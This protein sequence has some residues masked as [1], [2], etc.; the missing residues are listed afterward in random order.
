MLV[1]ASS[2]RHASSGRLQLRLVPAGLVIIV[3]VAVVV[4]CRSRYTPSV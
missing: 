4:G 3:L 1:I 2:Y